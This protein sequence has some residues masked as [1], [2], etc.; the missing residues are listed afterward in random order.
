M[1]RR[2][3]AALPLVAAL[4]GCGGTFWVSPGKY[5]YNSCLQMQRSDENYVKR[6]KE[7]EELMAR[8][9]Q[10]S[11]GHFIGQAVYRTEYQ[12]VLG[13]RQVIGAAMAEKRCQI[14]GGSASGRSVF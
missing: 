8:A 10:G 14:E 5:Q 1:K 6:I 3:I 7:L 4:A 9:A 2:S 13:E 11:G 12:Q